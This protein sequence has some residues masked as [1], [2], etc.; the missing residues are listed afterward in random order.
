MSEYISIPL[1]R[2]SYADLRRPILNYL[3]DVKQYG[4]SAEYE[5]AI[6]ELQNLR[7]EFIDRIGEKNDKTLNVFHR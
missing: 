6:T 3:D 2:G 4:S 7:Q 5:K 1:K